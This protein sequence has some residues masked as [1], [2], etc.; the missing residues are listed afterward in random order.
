MPSLH[1]GLPQHLPR[2]DVCGGMKI[3]M[4]G[5]NIILWQ[6]SWQHH[7][8]TT[9][10]KN[11]IIETLSGL[12]VPSKKYFYSIEGGDIQ[13]SILWLN[14][15]VTHQMK[16]VPHEWTMAMKICYKQHVD[17]WRPLLLVQIG[18]E[19]STGHYLLLAIPHAMYLL[20]VSGDIWDGCGVCGDN[21]CC[22]VIADHIVPCPGWPSC[23]ATSGKHQDRRLTNS[24][25]DYR[26]EIYY[27]Q[28][29]CI[30]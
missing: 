23:L 11:N 12:M 7:R 26:Q 6:G 19:L 25:G 28:I 1:C 18:D 29:G 3:N 10:D 4:T 16:D 17:R 8:L 14:V 5:M 15:S 2:T 9:A 27:L 24:L 20:P 22:A 21:C 30:W 13:I